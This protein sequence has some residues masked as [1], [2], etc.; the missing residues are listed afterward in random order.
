MIRKS[1]S[2]VL[3]L[4]LLASLGF[5]GSVAFTEPADAAVCLCDPT[6][7]CPPG[8]VGTFKCSPRC[9]PYCVG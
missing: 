6:V 8:L 9:Q 7:S 2:V 4:A 5:L 1:K 3:V